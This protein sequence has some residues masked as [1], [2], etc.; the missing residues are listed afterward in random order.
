MSDDGERAQ[1]LFR[2]IQRSPDFER[3]DELREFLRSD[4][5]KARRSALD[6]LEVLGNYK[7]ELYLSEANRIAE[8]LDDGNKEVRVGAASVA[9]SLGRADPERVAEM[10]P[11]LGA[12][13][14]DDYIVVRTNAVEALRYAA[15]EDHA[16]VAPY[17]EDLLAYF[18]SSSHKTKRHAV[19]AVA[20]VSLGEPEAVVPAV[21]ALFER[22]RIGQGNDGQVQ[23]PSGDHGSE[24]T[25]SHGPS[26]QELDRRDEALEIHRDIRQA[27]GHGLYEVAKVEPEAVLGYAGAFG[28]LLSDDDPQVNAVSA[29]VFAVLADSNPETVVEYADAV[30]DALEIDAYFVNGPA[31][32]ALIIAA[33]ADED[34]IRSAV[35]EHTDALVGLLDHEEETAEAAAAGLLSILAGDDPTALDPAEERLKRLAESETDFV[36]AA[37][38]DALSSR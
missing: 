21:P 8:L 7:P 18:D 19:S 5:P 17:V 35:A 23:R 12:L 36:R 1:E 30:A 22:F 6:A 10:V 3:V 38:E 29:D 26:R 24:S 16:A 33:D 20:T 27:A 2:E 37:A 14:E 11:S 13:L 32:R 4:D 31:A 28:E 34:A 15:Q 9:A 25:V